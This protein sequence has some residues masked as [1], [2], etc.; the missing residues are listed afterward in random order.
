VERETVV[1]RK[2]VQDAEMVIMQDL[3]DTT[4]AENAGVSSRKPDTMME[5]I[6]DAI[7][8]HLSDLASCD[9]EQS[10][11]D[12]ED[13]E[14]DTELGK[15]SDD[16]ETGWVMDSI[17]KTVQRH[18]DSFRQKQMTRDE[19]THQRCGDAAN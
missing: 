12:E 6:L 8:D 10:G 5:A 13:D 4:T 7:G 16:D 18:M 11:E 9:D 1:A 3:Q 14:E 19:L 17:T 2:R 15:L